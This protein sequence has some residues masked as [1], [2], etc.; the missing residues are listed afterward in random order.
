MIQGSLAAEVGYSMWGVI[1]EC[2]QHRWEEVWDGDYCPAN[3]VKAH[4]HRLSR[5]LQDKEKV[6][7]SLE[8]K[9][10]ERCKSPGSS[11][12]P[13]ESSR[14]ATSSSFVSEGLEPCSDGDTTSEC[15]RCRE[16][17]AQHTGTAGCPGATAVGWG[18]QYLCS[19]WSLQQWVHIRPGQ[20]LPVWHRTSV[21][22]WGVGTQHLELQGSISGGY[23]SPP[24]L[25]PD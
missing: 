18:H 8:V 7:E 14:S 16:E 6:I 20:G 15:S 12:P 24:R 22:A 1:L 19:M 13:S 3:S 25:G 17:P 9:L 21:P 2:A 23:H 4:L 11:R 5:E 10:Q